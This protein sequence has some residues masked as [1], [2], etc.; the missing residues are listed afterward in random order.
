MGT[1]NPRPEQLLSLWKGHVGRSHS[2]N[3]RQHALIPTQPLSEQDAAGTSKETHTCR[4]G[5]QRGGRRERPAASSSG[6]PRLLRGSAHRGI[7]RA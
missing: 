3:T 2:F 1:G 4:P 7:S 6:D 5:W